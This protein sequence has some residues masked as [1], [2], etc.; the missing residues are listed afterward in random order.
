[1]LTTDKNWPSNYN[2]NG[3]QIKVVSYMRPYPLSCQFLQSKLKSRPLGIDTVCYPA[4]PQLT[5]AEKIKGPKNLVKYSKMNMISQENAHDQQIWSIILENS[6][7][8]PARAQ[9]VFCLDHIVACQEVKWFLTSSRQESLNGVLTSGLCF[10]A[11]KI[12]WRRV[13]WHLRPWD[14]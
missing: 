7:V 6:V 13:M 1:M 12:R 5:W 8:P 11:P 3:A 14:F 10:G 9:R 2:L 4:Q